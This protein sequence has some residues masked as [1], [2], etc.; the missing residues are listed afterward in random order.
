MSSTPPP[1]GLRSADELNE[2][3]R[4]LLERTRRRLADAERAEY[5][6]LV[7]EWEAA[8]RGEMAAAA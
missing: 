4:A 2:Q 6:L 7:A 1:S 5:D 3:I 8:V